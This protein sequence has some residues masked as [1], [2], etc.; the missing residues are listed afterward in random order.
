MELLQET[1]QFSREEYTKA[2]EFALNYP[3]KVHNWVYKYGKDIFKVLLFDEGFYEINLDG[4]FV[5]SCLKWQ[6]LKK[7]RN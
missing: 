6:G 2:I 4:Q 1:G 7:W 5:R 3:P